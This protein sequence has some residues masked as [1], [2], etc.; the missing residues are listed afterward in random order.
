MSAAFKTTMVY[1]LL[2]RWL[3]YFADYTRRYN[4]CY[5]ELGH[6]YRAMIE[7]YDSHEEDVRKI[8]RNNNL[9]GPFRE[10]MR[11]F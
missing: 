7:A 1:R 3:D 9:L 11:R 10:W 4:V 5:R 6:A 8:E 2:K